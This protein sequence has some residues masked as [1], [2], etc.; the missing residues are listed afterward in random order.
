[1]SN[2]ENK[3]KHKKNKFTREIKYD[4]GFYEYQKRLDEEYA[5][6]Y[7]AKQQNNWSDLYWF[8]KSAPKDEY[9]LF[10]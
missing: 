6:Q 1:M 7:L 10:I 8:E 5:E 3:K 4:L 9:K 2:N